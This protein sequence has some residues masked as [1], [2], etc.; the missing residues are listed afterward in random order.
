MVDFDPTDGVAISLTAGVF[1][2]GIDATF[3]LWDRNYLTAGWSAPG[4]GQLFLLHRAFNSRSVGAAVGLGYQRISLNLET[5]YSCVCFHAKSVGSFG[6]R[7]FAI[8]RGH[9]GTGGG[10]KI[11]TYA[12][13]MPILERPILALT[14]TMGSY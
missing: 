1:V 14:L 10:I 2:A 11:G 8:L 5:N 4:R 6:V 9:G 13:Y 7:G 3:R 12:G